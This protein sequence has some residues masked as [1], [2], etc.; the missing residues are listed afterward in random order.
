MSFFPFQKGEVDFKSHQMRFK[1]AKSKD[2]LSFTLIFLCFT[3]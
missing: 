2:F 1:W 3:F